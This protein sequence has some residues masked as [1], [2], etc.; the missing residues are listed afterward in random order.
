MPRQAT[1]KPFGFI[2][3]PCGQIMHASQALFG[4]MQ[5]RQPDY[6]RDPE[7]DIGEPDGHFRDQDPYFSQGSGDR[8]ENIVDQAEKNGHPHEG[9]I[10]MPSAD[11]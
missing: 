2:G 5:V 8:E 9:E 1:I 3:R 10:Y 4:L 7:E 11:L 6:S